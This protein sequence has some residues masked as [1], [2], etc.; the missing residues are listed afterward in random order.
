M[1][2]DAY[3]LFRF[4]RW[5]DDAGSNKYSVFIP[6]VDRSVEA[7]DSNA[8]PAGVK[9]KRQSLGPTQKGALYH[10]YDPLVHEW[11]THFRRV[12]PKNPEVQIGGVS[13]KASNPL[14]PPKVPL[15]YMHS[16]TQLYNAFFFDWFMMIF[17]KTFALTCPFYSFES[18]RDL[19]ELLAAEVEM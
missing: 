2:H 12:H 11:I 3:H 7:D 10:E 19:E 16:K 15:Y 14:A 8:V 18:V 5:K 4:H 9:R 13:V 1:W 17:A 6:D